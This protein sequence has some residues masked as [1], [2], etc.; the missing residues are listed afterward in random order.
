[1]KCQGECN[2]FFHNRNP[3]LWLVMVRVAVGIIR[4]RGNILVCQRKQS[5]RYGLKWEF[6][7]GKIENGE[8]AADCLKRELMEELNIDASIGTLYHRHHYT[9]PDAGTFDVLYYIIT[10]YRGELQN[11][12]FEAIEWIPTHRL[13]SIDMLDG[14]REVVEKLLR[15]NQS[16]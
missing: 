6:P 2:L 9:Y 12:T 8:S 7:G 15:E 4:A 16:E 14:N 5:A 13:A 11:R 3:Y 10:S 1:M